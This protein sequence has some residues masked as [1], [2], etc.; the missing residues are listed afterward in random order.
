MSRGDHMTDVNPYIVG[1]LLHSSWGSSALEHYQEEDD[2][3]SLDLSNEKDAR[4]A[5]NRWLSGSWRNKTEESVYK[6]SLRYAITKKIGLEG[7]PWLPNIDNAPEKPNVPRENLDEWWELYH[8]FLLILWDE[9]FHEPFVEADLS[10]YRVRVD[11]EF[12]WFP[13]M[14][15]LWKEPIYE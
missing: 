6:E 5:I 3:Y 15:E 7:G 11:N 2:Y 12:V 1:R 9:W 8:Q 14:P 4:Y 10:N 13:H